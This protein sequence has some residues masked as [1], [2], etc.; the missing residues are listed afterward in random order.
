MRLRYLNHN[1]LIIKI[2]IAVFMI[3][4]FIDPCKINAENSSPE[5]Q[6]YYAYLKIMPELNLM[7]NKYDTILY[8]DNNKIDDCSSNLAFDTRLYKLS[9]GKHT[10]KLV[11]KDDKKV[12]GTKKFKLNNDSQVTIGFK[13]KSKSIKVSCESI[14]MPTLHFYSETHGRRSINSISIDVDTE[15]RTIDFM[16]SGSQSGYKHIE[17]T[18]TGDFLGFEQVYV[19]ADEDFKKNNSGIEGLVLQ[20]TESN[21]IYSIEWRYQLLTGNDPD[22]YDEVPFDDGWTGNRY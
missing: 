10:V 16:D 2:M 17:G 7:F 1:Q 6:E 21:T 22:S 11:K 13:K 14:K 5:P 8:L 15:K 3:F 19:E 9:K 12:K 20:L 18:Y 4:S